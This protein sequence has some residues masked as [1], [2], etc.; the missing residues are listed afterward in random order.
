MCASFAC[1]WSPLRAR[2]K[3]KED[4]NTNRARAGEGKGDDDNLLGLKEPHPRQPWSVA[5]LC[6]ELSVDLS[7][8]RSI[9]PSIYRSIDL[10]VHLSIHLSIHPFIYLSICLSIFIA[11]DLSIYRS[12]HP[13]IHLDTC[14]SSHPRDASDHLLQRTDTVRACAGGP[15][16]ASLN[17]IALGTTPF[18]IKC[19]APAFLAHT[20]LHTWSI[21]IDVAVCP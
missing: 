15:A 20:V 4:H 14:A 2:P 11:I 7:I 1:V 12:I 3:R 18:R 21:V 6:V 8:H 9:D 19:N 17:A 16:T 5:P 13:S 10:S